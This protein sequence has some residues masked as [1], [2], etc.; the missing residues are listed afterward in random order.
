MNI[1]PLR[2]ANY[3]VNIAPLSNLRS[4]AVINIWQPIFIFHGFFA[5]DIR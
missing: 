5:S 4:L 2:P 1:A 3:S